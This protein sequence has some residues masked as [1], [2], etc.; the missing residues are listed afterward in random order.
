MFH[1]AEEA[2]KDDVLCSLTCNIEEEMATPA[3]VQD[4]ALGHISWI[5]ENGSLAPCVAVDD[6]GDTYNDGSQP[7]YWVTPMSIIN[8]II[9]DDIAAAISIFSGRVEVVSTYETR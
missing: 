9:A 6:N 7:Y 3:D 8:S 5:A 4:S 2:I 1:I